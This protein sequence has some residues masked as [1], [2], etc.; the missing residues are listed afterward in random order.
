MSRRCT[1]PS[2]LILQPDSAKAFNVLGLPRELR[3]HIY[4]LALFHHESDGIIAPLRDGPKRCLLQPR[5]EHT[6]IG[7]NKRPSSMTLIANQRMEICSI[8][9]VLLLP[10]PSKVKEIDDQNRRLSDIYCASANVESRHSCTLDCLLQPALTYINRQVR[11]EV[12]PLF[13]SV[14]KFHFELC[15]FTLAV[16]GRWCFRPRSPVDW[17][18][19]IGDSNLRNIRQLNVFGPSDTPFDGIMMKYRKSLEVHHRA[20]IQDSN[21][22]GDERQANRENTSRPLPR[23][24]DGSLKSSYHRKL[25]RSAKVSERLQPH[26][27]VLGTEDLHVRVLECVVAE[28]ETIDHNYLRDEAALEGPIGVG[29]YVWPDVDVKEE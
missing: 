27:D 14:N 11:E 3:D 8:K 6:A 20:V 4:E 22:E 23:Y 25:R 5:Y 21:E 29:S 2:S 9:G 1:G 12:L 16:H 24:I 7:G 19:A 18:R 26:L 10:E 28:M 17:W 13:Y 15:N